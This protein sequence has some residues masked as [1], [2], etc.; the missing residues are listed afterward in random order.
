VSRSRVLIVGAGALGLTCAYHLQL[1]G[2]S[3]SF[4]VRAPR[5]EALSRPQR[6]YCYNDHDLKTLD[7]YAVARSVEEL[8]DEPF[9]FV[10][11]TLDGAGCRTEAGIATLQALG[12]WLGGNAARL[13][14]CGV[15]LGLYEH[16]CRV[17]GLGPDRVLEGTMTMLAYAVGSAGAPRPAQQD[18]ALHDSADLAYFR[19]PEGNGFVLS[20]RPVRG[21]KAFAALFDCSGVVR[22]I[23]MPRRVYRM[24][25]NLF[26]PFAVACALDGWRGTAALIANEE[27]WALC[28][29]SQREIMRLAEHGFAGKLAALLVNDTRMAKQLLDRE[30]A[31]SPIGFTAFNRYHHGGKLIG[32]AIQVL[33]DCVAAGRA[34]GRAM[35][36]TGALLERWKQRP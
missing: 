25:T 15:G 33:E 5:A 27:L 11:V 1:A 29:A 22:C 3:V 7:G 24:T 8:R 36:A 28:C 12:Q 20:S 21:A 6:L 13:L 16:V 14:I 26:F 10:L 30:E 34:K 9:D 2:A 23:L 35:P 32:Q 31:A 4:L 19:F 17:T 18:T